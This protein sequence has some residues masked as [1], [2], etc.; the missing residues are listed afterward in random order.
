M[1]MDVSLLCVLMVL[2]AS[3]ILLQWLELH[4]VLVPKDS[5]VMV[6]NATVRHVYHEIYAKKNFVNPAI[7]RF[8]EINF[9]E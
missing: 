4:A 2:S 1:L 3:I 6:Q 9:S 8:H 5:L 7:L